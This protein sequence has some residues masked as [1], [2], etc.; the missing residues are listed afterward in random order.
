MA[1]AAI[2]IDLGT[3]YSCVGVWEHGRVETIA[4]DQ[5]NRTTPSY[6]AF[7]DSECFVGDAA[8]NQAAMNPTNT[9]FDVK[10]II[11]RTINDSSLQSDMKLWPFKVIPG[12]DE[13]PMI[14]V[15]YNGEDKAFSAEQISAMVLSKMVKTAEAYIGSK[16]KKVVV[17]VPAY[18]NCSQRQATMDAG[19]IAG[20]DDMHI[21]NE[22]TAAGLAYGLHMKDASVGPKNVLIFDLG[23]G[24]FDVSL[25]TIDECIFEVKATAG[26][27]HLGGEDFDNRMI[28]Y[29]IQEFKKKHKIDISGDPKALRR[30]R[31]AC[32]RAKRILSTANS[33]MIDIDSLQH[34]IDFQTLI[35]RARFEGLNLDLFEKCLEPVEKCLKDARMNKSNI[36]Q[37]LLVGGSTRIP[38]VQSL[39][40]E[41]FDGKELCKS[42]NPDEAVAYGAAVQAAILSCVDDVEL[43]DWVL[44]DVTPLSLGEP[45]VGI[46]LGTTYSCVAVWEHGRVEI[47][48]NDQGNRTTPSYV[49]FTDSECFI[50]DAAKNQVGTNPTNSIFD[51]K[52]IIG[53]TINDTSVRSDME[54]WPF[55]VIHGLNDKPMIR[56][57]YKGMDKEFSAEQISAMVLSKMV[58]T[59]EAYIGSS[60]KKAVVTVPAYFN[61]SQRQATMDAGKIAGLDEMR[62]INEPTA[63]GLAYGLHMKATSVGVKNVLIFDL[64]GGTF[65][66]SLITIDDCIFEVKATAGDTHLGGEDFDNRM[67][68][69]YIQEFE[70]K[71]K[72][73]ISRDPKALAK[74]RTACERAKRTLSTAYN[75]FIDIDS[76]HQG[77]DFQ[78]H[79]TRARFEELNMD[80]FE[81]CLE[82]VEKCLKDAKMNKSSVHRILL[83]G[84][85]TRIPKVQCLLQE[86]FDGKELCKN[87]NPDEAVA[88]GAAVQ[89]AILNGVDDV[90]LQDCVLVDVTPLS[91][92]IRTHGGVMGVLI[93]RNTTIPTSKEMV[94][95]SSV[96]Y[97]ANVIFQVYEG[98]RTR[99]SDN[100]L[101]GEFMLDGISPAPI[102]S[103]QFTVRFD[104]NED[105]I[106]N[107]YAEDKESGNKNMIVIAINKGRL[108]TDEIQRLVQEAERFKLEDEEHGKKVEAMNSFETYA[109]SL[110]NRIRKYGRTLSDEKKMQDAVDIAIEWVHSD[111]VG[112]IEEI[113][114]KMKKLKDVC[115]P[116]ITRKDGA[117]AGL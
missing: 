90:E 74:L 11:G 63:A 39:L 82:P 43:Q 61:N 36:H 91:L 5:G 80:L 71:H 27:T 108:S 57:K 14:R 58:K 32:E 20:L 8:M 3:T 105:G 73:D 51:A 112:D 111:E 75:T 12:L 34:G 101:L 69:H 99:A 102:G 115:N 87:I 70:R 92:G 83:V 42:I 85:S 106:L 19:K 114:E 53:R 95:T 44:V 100:N 62:I 67:I 13:K 97:K 103:P 65:D 25:I 94:F 88:Y 49:A 40:Q 35:T 23:G 46:D 86:F 17:T 29:Y 30:L 41:F 26:D 96:D 38:K 89:A 98:E 9:I 79:I 109:Y 84:G 47:I 66:V 21:I 45:A 48:A 81:K 68:N 55:E 7:T 72:R 1:G 24:T 117:S 16:V 4:N 22:P 28:N 2:G 54:L 37:I 31:T 78:S 110:K 77:I 18:F 33:T 50:G 116:I 93:P 64:G 10:R 113:H 52:R 60:V 76:L 6:V 56:V 107:V 59:A 104:L 15:K